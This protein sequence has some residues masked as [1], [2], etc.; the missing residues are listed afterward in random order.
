MQRHVSELKWR[1]YAMQGKVG[2]YTN[3]TLGTGETKAVTG[4][5]KGKLIKVRD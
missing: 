2:R 3:Q 4:G 5:M 1:F